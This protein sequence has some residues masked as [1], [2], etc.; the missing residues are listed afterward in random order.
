VSVPCEAG[1]CVVECGEQEVVLTAFCGARR[2]AAT[3]PTER[4]A[5]CHRH[6][7]EHGPLI[8]ACATVAGQRPTSPQPAAASPPSRAVPHGISKLDYAASCRA[9][10][11]GSKTAIDQCLADEHRAYEHLTQGWAQFVASDKPGCIGL[12]STP[13]LQSYVELLTCLEMAR[14][15]RKLTQQ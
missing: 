15:A 4:S 14:D 5:S 6:G 11:D 13:G 9:I 3:Y 12:S 10:P 7:S 8:A 2:V 1:A